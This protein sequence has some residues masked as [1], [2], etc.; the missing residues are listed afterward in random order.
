VILQDE[1]AGE[2]DDHT[3]VISVA[4]DEEVS[5]PESQTSEYKPDVEDITDDDEDEEDFEIPSNQLALIG[6]PWRHRL[7]R[8]AK[9]GS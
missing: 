2:T 1:A 5:I 9:K 8:N 6:R 7:T 4:D 3:D